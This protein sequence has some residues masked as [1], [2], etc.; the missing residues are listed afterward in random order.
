MFTIVDALSQPILRYQT[1]T[2]SVITGTTVNVVKED[3]FPLACVA[4]GNPSP[5]YTWSA[6]SCQQYG[7]IIIFSNI[8]RI[9]M[10]YPPTMTM[11]IIRFMVVIIVTIIAL[12]IMIILIILI[13][14]ISVTI[15]TILS[16]VSALLPVVSL[17]HLSSYHQDHHHRNYHHYQPY[18]CCHER[19]QH[20]NQQVWCT[21]P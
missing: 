16:P 8:T 7:H 5:S 13:S 2:G 14:I 18:H 9:A 12:L 19:R 20:V 10:N 1:T 6:S 11:I 4:T 3:T 17:S 15:I 21:T